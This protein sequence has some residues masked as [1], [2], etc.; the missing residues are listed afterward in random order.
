MNRPYTR[1]G[2][3]YVVLVRRRPPDIYGSMGMTR[4]DGETVV[5]ARCN[6]RKTV[7]VWSTVQPPLATRLGFYLNYRVFLVVNSF[8]N[9]CTEGKAAL[10][11]KFYEI[12]NSCN[13]PGSTVFLTT[14]TTNL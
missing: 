12:L 10:R 4:R 8:I 9:P 2:C 11:L 14:P 5:S 6:D 3:T 13:I 7:A 1:N